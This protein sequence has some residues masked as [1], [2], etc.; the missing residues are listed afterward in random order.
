VVLIFARSLQVWPPGSY[1][2]SSQ[3]AEGI[4]RLGAAMLSMGL[5][6]AMPM[7]ALLLLVDIVFALMGKLNAHLQLLSL[8]FPAKMLA[9]MAMFSITLTALPTLFRGLAE[10]AMHALLRIAGR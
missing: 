3:I 2:I 7:I 10:Q 4:W 8:A 5:R 6:L 9:A 1:F